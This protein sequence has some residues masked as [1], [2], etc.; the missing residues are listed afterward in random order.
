MFGV[1]RTVRLRPVWH[2]GATRDNCTFG[3][4][5]HLNIL[6][7]FPFILY[8]DSCFYNSF[9]YTVSYAFCASREKQYIFSPAPFL[10]RIIL[11]IVYTR[12]NATPVPSEPCSTL[13]DPTLRLQHSNYYVIQEFANHISYRSQKRGTFGV[14][15]VY[16]IP[17]LEQVYDNPLS[18]PSRREPSRHLPVVQ[19]YRTFY[20]PFLAKLSRLI[21]S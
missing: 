8:F 11:P 5:C 10:P 14:A 6:H 20:H 16:F 13:T 21:T 4:V 19:Q 3:T 2:C 18:S 15:W 12:F 17:F 9:L 7:I 1:D